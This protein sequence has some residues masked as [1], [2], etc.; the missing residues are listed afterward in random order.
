VFRH[1]RG[2]QFPKVAL[3]AKGMDS[4][5][6]SVDDSDGI[7][8]LLVVM[9][10]RPIA[11]LSWPNAAEDLRRALAAEIERNRA[12]GCAAALA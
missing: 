4:T 2:V 11:D 8:Y 3:G 10:R 7:R 9:D 12:F 1:V 6:P 5:P